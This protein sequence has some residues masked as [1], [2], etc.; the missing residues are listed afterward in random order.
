VA[1]FIGRIEVC[2]LAPAKASTA[3]EPARPLTDRETEVIR[4]IAKG[5][6]NQEIAAEL[7]IS[8]NTVKSHLTGIQTKLGVRNRVEIAAWAW[9][10]ASW[11]P[12]SV[13]DLG[14]RFRIA[15]SNRS[16]LSWVSTAGERSL[17]GGR[18]RSMSTRTSRGSDDQGGRLNQPYQ[19]EPSRRDRAAVPVDAW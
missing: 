19:F 5:R 1:V 12:W 3:I 6:T 9:E 2:H 17:G 7:S 8:L 4:A 16:P 14:C 11:T 18:P 15:V 10:S 13:D